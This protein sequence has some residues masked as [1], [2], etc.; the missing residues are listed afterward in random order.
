[1]GA[2]R[3]VVVLALLVMIILF[4]VVATRDIKKA[5]THSPEKSPASF[6][7]IQESFIALAALKKTAKIKLSVALAAFSGLLDKT[8]FYMPETMVTQLN[9]INTTATELSAQLQEDTLFSEARPV[10]YYTLTNYVPSII[11]SYLDLPTSMRVEGSEPTLIAAEQL[12]KIIV[13]LSA[14]HQSEVKKIVDEL[15]IQAIFIEEKFRE[16]KDKN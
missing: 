6:N 14:M 4:V 8:Q 15:K 5:K 16:Y 2:L 1:M 9:T 13:A 11:K 12:D 10:V 3:L 7:D